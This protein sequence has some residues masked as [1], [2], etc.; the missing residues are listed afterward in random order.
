MSKPASGSNLTHGH[1]GVV[2]WFTGLS[3]AGKSTITSALAPDL[4]ASGKR[5]EVLDGD[6]VRTHLS[7][8]LTFSSNQFRIAHFPDLW[9]FSIITIFLVQDLLAQL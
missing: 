4:I 1:R 5:V 6:V 3:G 8:G 2:V 9:Y 7:K